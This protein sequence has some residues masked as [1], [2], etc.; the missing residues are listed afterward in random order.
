MAGLPEFIHKIYL[1]LRD[2]CAQYS[3][4]LACLHGKHVYFL[5]S[6]STELLGRMTGEQVGL[7]VA[8]TKSKKTLHL[9]G[10]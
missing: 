6:L 7:N 10:T 2:Y 4:H 5:G 9:S 8:Q 1:L 3:L